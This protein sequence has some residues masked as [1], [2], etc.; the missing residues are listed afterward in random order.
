MI[1]RPLQPL[2]TS[3][4]LMETKNSIANL[5][6]AERSE[7]Q[8][9]LLLKGLAWLG[10]ILLLTLRLLWIIAQNVTPPAFIG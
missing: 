8:R 2:A 5:V 6:F 9:Q 4:K 7:C 10:A 1:I 3:T